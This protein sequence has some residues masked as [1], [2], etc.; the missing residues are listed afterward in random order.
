MFLPLY[1]LPCIIFPPALVIRLYADP[2][3]GRAT[4]TCL[5]SDGAP[6]STKV[7]WREIF[8]EAAFR[9][10]VCG[11]SLRPTCCSSRLF[12]LPVAR[13]CWPARSSRLPTVRKCSNPACVRQQEQHWNTLARLC[14][15]LRS[16]LEWGAIGEYIHR[17]PS[18]QRISQ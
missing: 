18:N 10:T 13:T 12:A 9:N 8:Y 4:E 7:E 16:K 5:W 14:K 6:P 2:P 11:C 3:G 15:F 1:F 17:V